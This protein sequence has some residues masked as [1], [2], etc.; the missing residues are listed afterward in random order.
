LLE[1]APLDDLFPA[2]AAAGT[3]IVV[4][5]P[6]N[7]G[8]LAVGAK[9]GA[10]FNYEAAPPGVVA[11][12]AAIEAVC[13]AHGVPLAAA[14]LQFPLAHPLVASVIPGLDSPLRVEQALALYRHPIPAA[15]W[16]DL[17]ARGLMHGEAP[18]P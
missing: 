2:C 5:G 9:A 16:R 4:G 6:F 13:D 14:A 18:T 11:R 12:V 3:A 10:T 17:K 1:Q 8:I 7:S 15:L